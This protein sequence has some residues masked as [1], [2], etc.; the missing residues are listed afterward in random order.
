MFCLKESHVVDFTLEKTHDILS[1]CEEHDKSAGQLYGE[2]TR[3]ATVLA[4]IKQMFTNLPNTETLSAVRWVL[5][6]ATKT[7]R[8]FTHVRVPRDPSQKC[9]RGKSSNKHEVYHISLEQ[10]YEVTEFDLRM[11]AFSV[12]NRY[13]FQKSGVPMGG[14][15]SSAEAIITCAKAEHDF[16]TSLGEDSRR[17]AGNLLSNISMCAV[18]SRKQ[19]RLHADY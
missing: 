12:G 5:D 16:M 2:H 4:D 8:R 7:K 11:S 1:R 19:T 17:L 14:Y 15:I 18:T 3:Y 13:Y 9:S 10:I 6:R